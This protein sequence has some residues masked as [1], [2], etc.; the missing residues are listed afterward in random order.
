MFLC[1]LFL[2]RCAL[3]VP[4]IAPWQMLSLCTCALTRTVF[5]ASQHVCQ[6]YPQNDMTRHHTDSLLCARPVNAWL[7]V[8]EASTVGLLLSCSV[9]IVCW[10]R[11]DLRPSLARL[12]GLSSARCFTAS[13]I[14]NRSR[15]MH[16]LY[17]VDRTCISVCRN[18]V[19]LIALHHVTQVRSG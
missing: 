9:H 11:S 7:Y 6:N 10:L 1:T 17:H 15:V 16:S 4:R 14:V 13:A 8:L 18:V 19:Q 2:G 12:C 5:C 3:S